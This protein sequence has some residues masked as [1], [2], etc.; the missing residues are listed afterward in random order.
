M[1]ALRFE[2]RTNMQMT[3]DSMPADEYSHYRFVIGTSLQN[4]RSSVIPY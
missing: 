2:P 4:R 3:P 1:T